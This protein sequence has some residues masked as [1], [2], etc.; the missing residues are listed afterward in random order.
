MLDNLIEFEA[1]Q[2]IA[3]ELTDEQLVTIGSDAVD[4]FDAD[5]RSREGWD[6]EM[7]EAMNLALQIQEKK[8]FPWENSSNVKLPLLTEAAINF[9]S[10]MYPALIPP[11][12]IV[13]TRI[14]G[15]D[16]NGEKEAQS[17][18]VSKHMSYQ[19]L[20]EMEE[21]EEEMDA[22][23][24]IQPILG[25]MY[26][27][28]Y[29]DGNKG[30]NVS[31]MLSPAEFVVAYD[32]KN[33][34][35]CYRKT[36]ILEFTKNDIRK[37]VLSGDFLDVDLGDPVIEDKEHVGTNPVKV[38]NSTTYKFL[39]Q[40]TYLDLDQD[41]LEEPYII[42]VE[43]NSKKVVRIVAG[44]SVSNILTNEDNEIYDVPQDQYFTKY[45]FVP[46][47]DGSFLDLGLGKLLGPTNKTVNT[48]INQLIDAGTRSVT[49]GGFLG[50]GIKIKGGNLKFKMG[51]YKRV[52]STGDDLRKNI[53]HLPGTEPSGV[54]FNLLNLLINSGQR[55]ASTLDSQVGDNPGQNQ[56]A[57]TSAIVQENGQ[58][59]FNGIYK[60]NHRSLKSE[61]KK[62]FALNS[63]YLPAE[64]YLNVLD[65]NFPEDMAR[66]I[67]RSDYDVKSLNLIPAADSAYTS[68]QQRMAKSQALMQKIGTGLVNPQVA[69]Q[70]A[71]VAEEQ[72]GIEQIMKVPPAQPSLEQQEFEHKM[73]LEMAQHALEVLKTQQDEIKVRTDAILTLAKAESE[74]KGTQLNK[75]KLQL[76]G[77]IAEGKDN[78]ARIAA[79]NTTGQRGTEGM[80]NAAGG[81]VSPAT[82][83]V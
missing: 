54:L 18:R 4:G 39:E 25:N 12:D 34:E 79:L 82:A 8:N 7:K 48:L 27:K 36:H 17:I 49:G 66:T 20:E 50:R 14:V 70:R 9:N 30:R 73:K 38:D 3:E 58:K 37:R 10:M 62:I 35:T 13:K 46:N 52:D 21:W 81:E 76:D 11:T 43:K 67:A 45:G 56:K 61:L 60:R 22:G 74:E 31:E 55:L 65:G 6:G 5:M 64:S 63:V 57:T 44:Y 47:P 2:N 77:I 32:T 75:Y 59:I 24:I 41:D 1:L 26:K 71:L 15:E 33:L 69:I 51:E 72:S 68:Q 23:L 42:T 83:Q 29:Y 40:H 53:V 80:D 19:I 16:P 78:A 28:S